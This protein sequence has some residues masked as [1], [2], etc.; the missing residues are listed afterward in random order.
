M[1]FYATL[2]IYLSR[3]GT[4][5][6]LLLINLLVNSTIA[7]Q[8]TN[9]FKKVKGCTFIKKELVIAAAILPYS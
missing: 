8:N 6:I 5:T 3:L 2:E 4:P 9:N 7:L 1:L